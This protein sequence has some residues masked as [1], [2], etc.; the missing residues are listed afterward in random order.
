MRLDNYFIKF[1]NNLAYLDLKESADYELLNDLP[2]PIYVS[3]MQSGIL[4]GQMADKIDVENFLQGM[5]INIG[6]DPEFIHNEEYKS[7][8]AHYI[9]DVSKYTASISL[10]IADEDIDKALLLLRAGYLLNPLD[11]YNAYLYARLLWPRAYEVEDKFKDDFIRE[12]LEILQSILNKD[13]NFAIAYYELGN[14]YANLGEYVKSRNYYNNALRKTDTDEAC[15]EIRDRLSEIN[16]NAEIE[17]ALYFIGKGNYNEAIIKLTGLLSNKKRADAYYYLGVAYQNIEQYEN[18]IMAFE[19]SLDSGAEF[20][21]L[22][23]DYAISLYVSGK[24]IEAL[25]LIDEGLL[26]YPSDPRLAYN[27]IQ[28]NLTLGNLSRAKEDIEE[29][30][31]FD[32]LSDEIRANLMTIKNQFKI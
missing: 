26:K 10:N 20:R 24:E 5:L 16:D 15:N 21:E 11:N 6:A 3:D 31:T 28:I 23:N 17:E 4:T 13:N 14:I 22:Y 25:D 7:I 18:S 29:L 12:S 8:I 30:L 1:T 32:D 27:K 19:N 2:L 9:P